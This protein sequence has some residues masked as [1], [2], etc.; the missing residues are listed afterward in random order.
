MYESCGCKHILLDAA[1]YQPG[2]LPGAQIFERLG[3]QSEVTAK[4]RCND[5]DL[6][7]YVRA[8]HVKLGEVASESSHS[9]GRLAGLCTRSL[10][11]KY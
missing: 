10:L 9:A 8:H 1:A 2:T 3:Q 5:C 6:Q 4:L 7:G 11:L